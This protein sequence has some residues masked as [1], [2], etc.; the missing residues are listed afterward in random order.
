S[1]IDNSPFCS[2]W[3]IDALCEHLQAVTDGEIRRLLINISPRSGKTLVS[4]VCFPAWTWA[5]RQ[6]NYLSGPNVKFLC[7]SYGHGL[8]IL[9]SNLNRRL[10]LSPWYQQRWGS[11]FRLR[12]DQNTKTQFDNDAGGSRL[13]TSVGGSLLG[14]GADLVLVDDPHN[15]D[16]AES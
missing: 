5:R 16:Q 8:S 2:S 3:A 9:N 7:G 11:R 6:L 4:S 1:T 14:L 12:V 10:I 15:T 13:A